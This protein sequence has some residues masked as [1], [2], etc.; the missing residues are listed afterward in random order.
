MDR[1]FEPTMENK[2]RERLMYWW[3]KA[4]DRTRDWTEDER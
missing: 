2:E 4:V 1:V 3:R